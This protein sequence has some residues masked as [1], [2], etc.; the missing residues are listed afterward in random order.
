LGRYEI[1]DRGGVERIRM[2]N[3]K[4]IAGEEERD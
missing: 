1:K 2:K 4:S 3:K